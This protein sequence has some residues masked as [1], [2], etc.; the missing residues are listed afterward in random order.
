MIQN[1]RFLGP[2]PA[3]GVLE[4]SGGGSWP[5]L[6]FGP[7]T[8]SV[9][10]RLTLSRAVA[11]DYRHG[12]AISNAGAL[13]VEN[14][15]IVSNRTE[16]GWGGGIYNA[17]DLALVEVELRANAALGAKGGNSVGLAPY[18]ITNTPGAGGAG[19]GGAVFQETGTLKVTRCRLIANRASGGANGT[20]GYK[21]S[22]QG[23]GRGGGPFGGGVGQEGGFGSGGGGVAADSSVGQRGGFGGG[24]SGPTFGDWGFGGGLG[25]SGDLFFNYPRPG[26]GAG[27]GGG[28]FVRG[29]LVDLQSSVFITNVAE[30][31]IIQTQGGGSGQGVGA[32]L[33]VYGGEVRVDRCRFESGAARMAA[34]VRDKL[35]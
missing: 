16:G 33:L 19:F 10:S 7:G 1:V 13:W 2:E 22:D 24:S 23:N 6:S 15:L 21:L 8:T 28:I 27:M 4:V 29:G 30:G 26:A 32:S 14:C 35:Y 3:Q 18:S 31:G 5:L 17:G 34:Q 11:K 20:Y 12:A 9:I 25:S